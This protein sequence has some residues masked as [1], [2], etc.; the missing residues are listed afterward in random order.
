MRI[1]QSIINEIK[2]KTDILDL[3]SE[4]VKLEKRGRN[5]IGLCPFHDEKTPS[6]TVSE[7]KQ[8]CH[9]FGC[10]K[11]GNVF[12]FTQ[13]IKD[14]SFVE[15]VKELGDR[16]NVAVDIEATQSN[17]NVQIASDDLQMIE[18]HELIQEFYYYALTKT[19]EGEQALTYLQERGFTDALI[20]ERG[21]GF[22]P[23]S[24]HFCHDFLQKK[25]YD[26]ELAYEAGLL[27]RN[28]ENFSYYDRFRNRIM[29]PLKNAQGRIVGY[30]GRTYTGQE[31]K[32]L[33]SPETP[34]FQKRKLL[35][36]LD[37]AR[38]SIRKLDE[39]VLLEGFIDVIKSDTAGLKNVVATM[40]TQLSDEHITFIRKLTSNITLMFDGDFAGSE[41]TLKTGQ[42]LLQQGLN[43]FVIQL[44]SGMDPDEY[45]GKYGNDAFTAFVK[46]DKK[47]FAHYKVSILKDEIAHNDLSYE[48]YLKELSHDISLMKSSILQ[49]KALNDVAPFFNVSPEQLANEIQ[50]NQAPANYYPEDEYGGYIEPEPIGMAQFDNLSRQEKAERAFLK[51]LMRDKDTFLNYYESVDKDNFTNQHFKYVFEVLHDFYAENDQYNISDAVQYVN[52]NELRETLISLEQYNLNDEPYENEI[53]D[54]VNVIN[55]KGQET[56]ESLNHKLREATRI[57][58]VELQKYYLQ[59]IVAKNKERM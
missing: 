5:Y 18:M 35:Y 36:N 11:G 6:F 30:S 7:D 28:E 51:H 27:S 25:G 15:A 43:V 56:I 10:K 57:G 8:I 20:K 53:D 21:I 23:D 55:E 44:P 39:I 2:D 22:A 41:A 17:S 48:R 3:V 46:N 59:Q 13:E 40:G 50:F 12:Q 52:S 14:I 19:V 1:D 16:V 29:F 31:P 4:Y 32:Y 42:N 58:D 45:I 54:Y 26:I 24:S 47:S 49:Q 34:I 33:N 37:K 9:C 38:K